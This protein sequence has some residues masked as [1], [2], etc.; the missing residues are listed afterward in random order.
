[1]WLWCR[2]YNVSRFFMR[3][4]A[5]HREICWG[6]MRTFLGGSLVE[7]WNRIVVTVGLLTGGFE[8]LNVIVLA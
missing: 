1:L 3:I 6:S 4:F 7:S 5:C 8:L 2:G